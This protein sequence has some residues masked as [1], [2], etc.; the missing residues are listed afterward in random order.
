VNP[1]HPGTITSPSQSAAS[2]HYRHPGL[3]RIPDL[4]IRQQVSAGWPAHPDTHHPASG[5]CPCGL[6]P[7]PGAL[8]D[9]IGQHAAA[10]GHRLI[11]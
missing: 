5:P 11:L 1:D 10:H 2:R 7:F 9:Q 3:V 8:A 4:E 6:E